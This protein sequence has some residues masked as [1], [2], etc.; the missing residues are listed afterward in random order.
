MKYPHLPT[1]S[2]SWPDAMLWLGSSCHAFCSSCR[3]KLYCYTVSTMSA[4][5]NITHF[6]SYKMTFI[7]FERHF[8]YAMQTISSN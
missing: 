2:P 5:F 3:K 6:F 7:L 4:K 8:I 1:A